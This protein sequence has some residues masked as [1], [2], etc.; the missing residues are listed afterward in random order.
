MENCLIVDIKN[1]ECRFMLFEIDCADFS[2]RVEIFD[3]IYEIKSNKKLEHMFDSFLEYKVC[4]NTL[5]KFCLILNNQTSKNNV[6]LEK[7][8]LQ[9]DKIDGNEIAKKYNF[10]YCKLMNELEA[11]SY[12]FHK[13]QANDLKVNNPE[14]EDIKISSDF[15]TIF[16]LSLGVGAGNYIIRN[17][18]KKEKYDVILDENDKFTYTPKSEEEKLIF[19]FLK[20]QTK[21]EEILSQEFFL[22]E[23]LLVYVFSYFYAKFKQVKVHEIPE[24][25]KVDN[26]VRVL[27]LLIN[28]ENVDLKIEFLNFNFQILADLLQQLFQSCLF[29]G[30]FLIISGIAYSVFSK[31]FS[32][33]PL[34]L[35][36]K[37][38]KILIG[39]PNLSELLEKIHLKFYSSDEFK[40]EEI[41]GALNYVNLHPTN[42]KVNVFKKKAFDYDNQHK[43]I[44][45]KTHNSKHD[46]SDAKPNDESKKVNFEKTF[47]EEFEDSYWSNILKNNVMT[48]TG[49]FN[50][51]SIK[52][53]LLIGKVIS[54]P[55]FKI[56]KIDKGRQRFQ[57]YNV[58]FLDTECP[59]LIPTNVTRLLIDDI[60]ILNDKDKIYY[61]KEDG[62][63]FQTNENIIS[64]ISVVI[65]NNLVEKFIKKPLMEMTKV[66]SKIKF[67][68]GPLPPQN[69]R[70]EFDPERLLLAKPNQ[71]IKSYNII[72]KVLEVFPSVFIRRSNDK[73]EEMVPCKVQSQK[74]A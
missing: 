8:E 22:N 50:S 55:S 4:K 32:Q 16:A 42:S 27:E 29:G 34:D 73:V 18:S 7:S 33:N 25:E 61:T 65:F 59:V 53:R 72:L 45:K 28:P 30:C 64:D 52:S 26:L 74:Y 51:R 58:R 36:F 39:Q 60:I 48:M 1:T 31:L 46:A 35:K 5:P 10:T 20:T 66:H 49:F 67:E 14:I 56:Y 13:S 23:G 24:T 62:W 54:E 11:F 40:K 43:P 9:W 44:I 47:S 21:K 15:D 38:T 3:K 57:C 6:F 41:K 69:P 70:T 12:C 2:K 71:P 68:F 37:M 17:F 19:D 63:Y